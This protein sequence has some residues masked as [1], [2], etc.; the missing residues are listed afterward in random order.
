MTMLSPVMEALRRSRLGI[1]TA[2]AADLDI[3]AL[4]I[5][6]TVIDTCMR[7]AV[8][9]IT[10]QY[11]DVTMLDF[12]VDLDGVIHLHAMVGSGQE[13]KHPHVDMVEKGVNA[14]AVDEFT[15]EERAE[16]FHGFSVLAC[17]IVRP[18]D[19]PEAKRAFS[20]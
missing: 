12:E 10:T 20:P 19:A 3:E 8:Y 1:A 16:F 5:I 2:S 15:A 18:H 7:N 14:F 4:P 13:L 6:R 11:P 17:G 9:G